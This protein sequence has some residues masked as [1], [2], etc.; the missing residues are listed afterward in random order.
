MVGI[1]ILGHG[2]VAEGLRDTTFMIAGPQPQVAAVPFDADVELEVYKQGV[3][4]AAESVDTGDGVLF[5]ADLKGGTPCNVAALLSYEKSWRVVSGANVPM[6]VTI[7]LSRDG[8]DVAAL[9][10]LARSSGIEG[11]EEVRMEL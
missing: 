7:A 9:A 10:E 6:L 3:F 1:V 4:K 11:V 5:T 8:L 2:H